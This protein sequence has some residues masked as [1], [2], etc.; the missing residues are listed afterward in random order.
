[1]SMIPNRE[2]GLE[3]A[4]MEFQRAITY[5]QY[6]TAEASTGY[7]LKRDIKRGREPTP[8]EREKGQ[9]I[10]WTPL[11]DQEKI[12][13]AM[14]T[15]KRHIDRALWLQDIVLS[16]LNDNPESLKSAQEAL[17]NA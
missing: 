1:M 13:Q 10:G 14:N 5:A 17:S 4:R 7:T 8:E 2:S 9:V 11:T 15:A 12:E 16:Y 6:W 3:W